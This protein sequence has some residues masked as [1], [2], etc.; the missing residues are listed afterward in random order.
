MMDEEKGGIT[1]DGSD[2]FNYG[3]NFEF[4]E[5]SIRLGKRS[6]LYTKLSELYIEYS[7]KVNHINYNIYVKLMPINYLQRQKL[8]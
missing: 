3:Y 7:S 6:I 5:K 1:G 4:T 8:L 2:D